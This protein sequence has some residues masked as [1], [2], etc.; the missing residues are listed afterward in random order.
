[1]SDRQF[2][3]NLACTGFRLLVDASLISKSDKHKIFAT[4]DAA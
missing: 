3:L 2:A 4:F 1:M